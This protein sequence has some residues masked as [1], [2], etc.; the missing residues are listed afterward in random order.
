MKIDWGH[1]QAWSVGY[2]YWTMHVDDDINY[3]AVIYHNNEW[4]MK[5]YS[6]PEWEIRCNFIKDRALPAPITNGEEAMRY[7]EALYRLE[8]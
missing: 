7:V 1:C 8:G 2:E 5:E 3:I 4:R 6:E